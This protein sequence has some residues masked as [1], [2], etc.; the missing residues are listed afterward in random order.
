MIPVIIQDYIN[1]L[2]EKT[3][4]PERRQFYH[5]TLLKIRDS[6]NQALTQYDQE[7]KIRK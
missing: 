7:R 1:K 5:N 4:H 6:I 3:T 2:L